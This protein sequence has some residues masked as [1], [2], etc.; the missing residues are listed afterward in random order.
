MHTLY[1][2]ADI[3]LA[4]GQKEYTPIYGLVTWESKI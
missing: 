2:A 3:A 1:K 4:K